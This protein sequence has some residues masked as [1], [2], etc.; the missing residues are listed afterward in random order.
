ML[1][2]FFLNCQTI[3]KVYRPPEFLVEVSLILLLSARCMCGEQAKA[4]FISRLNTLPAIEMAVRTAIPTHLVTIIS[5]QCRLICV[6][7][8][9]SQR[10][11]TAVVQLTGADGSDLDTCCVLLCQFAALKWFCSS[12]RGRKCK[13]PTQLCRGCAG[14]FSSAISAPDMFLPPSMHLFF[15]H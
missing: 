1:D 9:W 15:N 14:F 4:C 5:C 8:D 6:F 13:T 3:L 10:G 12:A 7:S 2:F 11:Y